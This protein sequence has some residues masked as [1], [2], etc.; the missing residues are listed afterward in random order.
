MKS[1]STAPSPYLIGAALGALDTAAFLTAERGLGVTTPFENTAALLSKKVAPN[2]THVNA[3]LKMRE[4][5]PKIDWEAFLVA[6]MATGSFLASRK[7]RS[8]EDG[9]LAKTSG[10]R[11]PAAFLGGALMMFGARMAKGCTSGHGLTGTMQLAVSSWV[12][13][14]LM[15]AS[16]ILAGKTLYPKGGMTH[17]K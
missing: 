9:N 13:T 8:S 7:E 17:E 15:F 16:A 3:Y 2:L 11:I 6:G 1:S 4:E 12:F 5:K 10:G 14:P